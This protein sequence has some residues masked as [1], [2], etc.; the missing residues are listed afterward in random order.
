VPSDQQSR[1]HRTA[2][3]LIQKLETAGYVTS[4]GPKKPLKI[5]FPSDLR[6]ACFP[7]LYVGS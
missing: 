3:L 4:D 1:S 5:A 7:N 6:D 2:S